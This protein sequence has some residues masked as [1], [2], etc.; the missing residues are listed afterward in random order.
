MHWKCIYYRR[1]YG[2][3]DFN[4]GTAAFNLTSK[5]DADIYVSKLD[6]SGNF[7]WAKQVGGTA[8]DAGQ[9]LALN[10]WGYE[11]ITG[12]FSG[13]ADFNPGHDSSK[14]TV[15]GPE[16][17]ESKLDSSGNFVWAKAIGNSGL[18]FTE[19]IALDTQ[20]N[21]YTTGDFTGTA[22]FD[23]GPDTFNLSAEVTSTENMMYLYLN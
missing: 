14:I 1:F 16:S 13:T 17:F 6:A 15:T 23:P 4:P 7:V 20:S 19:S 11:Y 2:T 21:V 10:A 12:H 3:T 8:R 5:G 22:D 18:F 9:G